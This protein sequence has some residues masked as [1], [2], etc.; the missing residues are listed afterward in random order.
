VTTPSKRQQLADELVRV[1]RSAGLTGRAMARILDVKQAQLYRYDKAVTTP[2]IPKVRT[3]LDACRAAASESV[4]AEDRTRIVALAEDA[5]EEPRSWRA[6]H[7]VGARS[8]QEAIAEQEADSA[9]EWC[10]E[11][12]I[13]PG[14]L[15]TPEYAMAAVARADLHGQFDHHAQVAGRLARQTQMFEPGRRW[16]FL[17]AERLLTWSPG[18]TALMPPQ[19]ARLASLAETTGVQVAVLPETATLTPS[20][21]WWAPFTIVEP[22]GGARYVVIE[23][24]HGEQTVVAQDEVASFRLLWERMWEVA[25]RGAEALALIRGAG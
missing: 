13:L 25:A 6:L 22:R 23:H 5:H 12:V 7:D 18:S 8:T 14:L 15:Q 10:A 17:I 1:R 11:S 20:G 4:S 21:L 3:W 19:R 2:S 16:W 9:E 24:V